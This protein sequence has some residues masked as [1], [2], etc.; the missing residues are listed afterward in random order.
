MGSQPTEGMLPIATAMEMEVSKFK[1]KT[2]L[3]GRSQFWEDRFSQ[4]RFQDYASGRL[5]GWSVNILPR[6]SISTERQRNAGHVLT[7]QRQNWSSER[8]I[9]SE[10]SCTTLPGNSPVLT[11]SVERS[12]TAASR[13]VNQELLTP[14]MVR[15][16]LAK[17]RFEKEAFVRS[18][19]EKIVATGAT[20]V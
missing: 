5:K 17:D 2:A 15:H 11:V 20:T 12:N 18:I 19:A 8:A 16:L 9:C 1:G 6:S 13:P 3:I 14:E 4:A 7:G 10:V